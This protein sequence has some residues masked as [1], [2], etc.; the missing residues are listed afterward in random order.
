MLTFIV[1]AEM[2]CMRE[3]AKRL[4]AQVLDKQKRDAMSPSLSSALMQLTRTDPVTNDVNELRNAI[5]VELAK[6]SAG[7]VEGLQLMSNQELILLVRGYDDGQGFMYEGRMSV[8]LEQDLQQF[9]RTARSHAIVKLKITLT[10]QSH[11]IGTRSSILL[12]FLRSREIYP[13]T[14]LYRTFQVFSNTRRAKLAPTRHPLPLYRP[15]QS[16]K[17][18]WIRCSS[19]SSQRTM[20][21]SV[22]Y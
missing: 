2:K 4:R 19:E 11:C 18:G 17:S 6:L 3:H 20:F 10:G 1:A 12:H 5:I 8:V 22:F 13:V 15:S 7:S 21:D 16:S 14:R 9:V